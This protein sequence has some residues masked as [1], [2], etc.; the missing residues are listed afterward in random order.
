MADAMI[1]ATIDCGTNYTRQLVNDG[2]RTVERLM[3]ITRLGEKVNE[4]RRLQPEA[5]E[6]TLAVLREYREVM[7]T[8]VSPG[9][10]STT[11][12]VIRM[13]APPLPRTSCPPATISAASG[14]AAANANG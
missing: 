10:R 8:S 5:I 4:T 3:R 9:A 7:V 11:E 14:P 12:L 1:V 6:R 13:S 2:T